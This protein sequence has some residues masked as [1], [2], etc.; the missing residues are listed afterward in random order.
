MQEI[1]NLCTINTRHKGNP[2]GEPPGMDLLQG[3]LHVCYSLETSK[4]TGNKALLTIMFE[5]L[6]ITSHPQEC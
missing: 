3:R 5:E 4:A 2:P 6:F 1:T